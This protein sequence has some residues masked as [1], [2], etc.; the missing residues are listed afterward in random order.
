MEV[1]KFF[2]VTFGVMY[3]YE[4]HPIWGRAHPD[5]LLRVSAPDLKLATLATQMALGTNYAFIYPEKEMR[6][7]H[8]PL[9][10]IGSITYTGIIDR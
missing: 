6:W 10:V 3:R 2:Y 1:L 5:G 4:T 7:E 8:H 9:G